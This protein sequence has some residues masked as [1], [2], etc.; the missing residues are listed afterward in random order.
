MYQRNRIIQ[1]KISGLSNQN[2]EERTKCENQ[3]GELIQQNRLGLSLC[4]SNI[5]NKPDTNNVILTYCA[6]ILWNFLLKVKDSETINEFWKN[7]TNEMK[8]SIKSKINHLK[9]KLLM[10][11]MFYANL[12]IIVK[13]EIF[14]KWWKYFKYLNCSLFII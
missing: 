5:L 4:L 2:N 6:V 8:E 1:N 10:L 7:G 13:V 14:V 9:K 11:L 3:L 12:F